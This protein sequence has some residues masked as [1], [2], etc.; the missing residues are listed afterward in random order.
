MGYIEELRKAVGHRPLILVGAVVMI[1]NEK[2]E[3]LLQQRRSPLG[4]WGLPGGLMELAESTEET[5]RR[6]VKEETSLELGQLHLLNVYS[7]ADQYIKAENG[8]EFYVVTTAYYTFDYFGEWKAD[9][10]ESIELAFFPLGEWPEKMV[11]SHRAML[12]DYMK[13]RDGKPPC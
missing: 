3:V 7:G 1:I 9:E 2:N 13:Q 6:E 10:S 11:G 4:T 5:A 12:S 8:D